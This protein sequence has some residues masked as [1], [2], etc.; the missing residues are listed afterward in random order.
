MT[1]RPWANKEREGH[2]YNVLSSVFE[3]FRSCKAFFLASADQPDSRF[4]LLQLRCGLDRYFL[5]NSGLEQ[6]IKD[7]RARLVDHLARQVF[8]KTPSD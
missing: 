3:V 6:I 2:L 7:G 1:N 8:P 4:H 5:T